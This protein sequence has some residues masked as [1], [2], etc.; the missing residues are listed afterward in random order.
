MFKKIKK[1]LQGLGEG[2][3]GREVSSKVFYAQA[4][5]SEKLMWSLGLAKKLGLRVYIRIDVGNQS[6]GISVQG[7][8]DPTLEYLYD[9]ANESWKASLEDAKQAVLAEQDKNG[10]GDCSEIGGWKGEGSGL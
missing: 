8:D 4:D 9:L 10:V 7:K 5:L 6:H 2:R 3:Q 1:L